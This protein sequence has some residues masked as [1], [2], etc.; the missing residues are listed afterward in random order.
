[1]AAGLEMVNLGDSVARGVALAEIYR[2]ALAQRSFIIG[3]MCMI[4]DL[5][6]GRSCVHACSSWRDPLIT[7]Y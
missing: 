4:L 7:I 5:T 3:S 2:P 6:P 1:M